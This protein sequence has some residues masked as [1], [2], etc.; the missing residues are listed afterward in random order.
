[1]NGTTGHQVN[2]KN[3][4]EILLSFSCFKYL[5]LNTKVYNFVKTVTGITFCDALY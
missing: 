1:M 2:A 4:I 5:I 3:E